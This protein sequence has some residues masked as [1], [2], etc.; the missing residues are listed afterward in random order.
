[1]PEKPDGSMSEHPK[2]V[3]DAIIKGRKEE[4]KAKTES[5]KKPKKRGKNKKK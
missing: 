2:E 1:M 4:E 5:P 3:R